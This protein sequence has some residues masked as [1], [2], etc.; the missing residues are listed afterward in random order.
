MIRM[1]MSLIATA[2]S[3]LAGIGPASA[4]ER[5]DDPVGDA[6]GAAPDIVAVT[7]EDTA[8]TPV[9]G[10]SI[11]LASEPPVSTDGA[12][13]TDVVFIGLVTEP[14]LGPDGQ[15][16][17][18]ATLADFD[19]DYVI[20]AHGVTL[21]QEIDTGGHLAVY[22]GGS[23]L[24]WF[25]VDVAIDGPTLTW[26]LDRKLIGD[27][28]ALALQVLAG[29]ERDDSGEPEYDVLPDEGEPFIVYTF[30]APTR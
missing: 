20:G 7:I 22:E 23:E 5:H 29:V 14:E 6:R 15:A 11:E 1:R 9:L 18:R 21:P 13:W 2:T 16:V 25:V 4:A 24:Y 10:I 30:S 28:D 27:P 17:S 19:A 3:L 26:S 12:T 8:D